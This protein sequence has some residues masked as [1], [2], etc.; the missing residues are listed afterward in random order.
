MLGTINFCRSAGGM[1]VAGAGAE[2][3][4]Y[5]F[6]FDDCVGLSPQ[7]TPSGLVV[8]FEPDQNEPL[9]AVNVRRYQPAAATRVNRSNAR[10]A[11]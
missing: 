8:Q 7:I 10:T 6:S 4:L 9:R 11:N 1:I 3:R 5:H 2:R